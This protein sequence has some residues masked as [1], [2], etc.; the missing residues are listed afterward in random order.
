MTLNIRSKLVC[1]VPFKSTCNTKKIA[2]HEKKQAQSLWQF[3][4]GNEKK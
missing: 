1:G 4:N 2:G 3:E